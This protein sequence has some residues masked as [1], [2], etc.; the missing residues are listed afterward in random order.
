VPVCDVDELWIHLGERWDGKTGVSWSHDGEILYIRGQELYITDWNG[1][2]VK[3]EE[4][5][6][7]FR[8]GGRL[9]DFNL[10]EA[11]DRLV[12]QRGSCYFGRRVTNT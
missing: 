1:L 7:L 4:K 3:A 2:A 6:L 10:R 8:I 5:L 9:P 12:Q 11:E